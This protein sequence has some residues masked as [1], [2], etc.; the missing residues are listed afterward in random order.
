MLREEGKNVRD[1][2]GQDCGGF[3]MVTRQKFL[4]GLETREGRTHMQ[5]EP[6]NEG[7]R[8]RVPPGEKR[9][10]LQR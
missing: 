5:A 10:K 7:F 8:A 3:C 2:K 9:P 6:W 4:E 1:D